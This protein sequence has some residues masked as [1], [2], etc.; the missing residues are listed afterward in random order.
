MATCGPAGRRHGGRRTA[1]RRA[2]RVPR[3]RPRGLRGPS[4]TGGQADPDRLATAGRARQPPDMVSVRLIESMRPGAAGVLE[5]AWHQAA[6]AI[7]ANWHAPD[8]QH[9]YNDPN[10][11]PM[12]CSDAPQR[13]PS[14]P[15][16]RTTDR[17]PG[18]R[19]AA[20]VRAVT[21]GRQRRRVRRRRGRWSFPG[22]SRAIPLPSVEPACR[23]DRERRPPSLGAE[24]PRGAGTVRRR[25]DQSQP[26]REARVPA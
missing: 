21:S 17:M 26:R 22:P 8:P 18:G 19:A 6:L 1:D 12:T 20:R 23:D 14:T 13:Q 11:G 4:T 10:V 7:C 5:L 24:G 16:R 9:R 15:T 2:R 25:R 3:V